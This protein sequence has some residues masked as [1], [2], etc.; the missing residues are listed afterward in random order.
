M[1]RIF[2]LS[3]IALSMFSKPILTNGQAPQRFNYQSV[4]RNPSG[5]PITESN[6]GLRISIRDQIESGAILYQETHTATTNSF[7]LFTLSVG[8]GTVISGT[9]SSINWGSG[10]KFLEVEADFNGGTSYSKMGSAQLLSVPY[11]LYSGN[12]TTGPQGVQGPV[13]PQGVAGLQGLPGTSGQNG[14]NGLNILNDTTDPTVGSH[15]CW[16]GVIL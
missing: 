9:F 10:A 16:I 11:A 2:Q 5:E 13:G 15:Q 14:I 7:G 4:A 6:I 8:G 3:L 1:K 12:G